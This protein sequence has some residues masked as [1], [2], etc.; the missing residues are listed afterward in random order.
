MSIQSA[1]THVDLGVTI[2]KDLKC[3]EHVQ[4]TVHKAGGLAHSLLKS[5]VCRSSEFMFFL[6]T[7]HIRPTTEY[8]ACVLSIGYSRHATVGKCTKKT[9][10]TE[11]TSPGCV[12]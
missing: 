10:K 11:N 6:L 4:S 8:C 12:T 9:D 1:T 2:D 5:T 3:H 7:A